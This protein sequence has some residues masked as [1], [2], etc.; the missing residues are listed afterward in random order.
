MSLT[1]SSYTDISNTPYGWYSPTDIRERSTLFLHL[2]GAI[3]MDVALSSDD[4]QTL[5]EGMVASNL[6][7]KDGNPLE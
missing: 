2:S 5:V 3:H 1:T 4:I 7:P 6:L